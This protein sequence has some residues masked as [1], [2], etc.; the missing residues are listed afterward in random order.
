MNAES[1]SQGCLYTIEY[2][3]DV[4]QERHIAQPNAILSLSYKTLR[5][6]S[7][8]FC[9]WKHKC[10]DG[11]KAFEAM[12]IVCLWDVYGMFM[13]CLWDVYCIFIEYL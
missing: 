10:V 2:Q 13:V 11:G 6:M 1:N 8:C 5:E 3:E 9:D 4:L 7:I 12:F